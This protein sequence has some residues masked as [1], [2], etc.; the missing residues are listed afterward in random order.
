[1]P[2]VYEAQVSSPITF[3]F[4][5]IDGS[6]NLVSG[7]AA[8]VAVALRDEDGAAAETVTITEQGSSG[9]YE[10]TFT[11]TKGASTGASY[12]LQLTSPAGTDGAIIQYPI[13]VYSS[14][15]PVSPVSGSYLT[16]LAHL[17]QMLGIPDAT[18]TY[19]DLL[20]NVIAR[21]SRMIEGAL[22]VPIVEASYQEISDGKGS[23]VHVLRRKP[24]TDV[25]AVYMGSDDTWDS[26]TLVDPTNYSVDANLPRIVLRSGVFPWGMLN[27]RV[28]YTAGYSTIPLDVEGYCLKKCVELW[29]QRQQLGLTSIS[30]KDGS[31]SRVASAKTQFDDLMFEIGQYAHVW[32]T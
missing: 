18:T 7:E 26:T 32:V 20:T 14:I 25:T 29:N 31:I 21:M 27:V 19:D 9:Y 28:D 11:P 5:L 15:T 6:G 10:A 2:R 22:G 13:R 24:V 1:M 8:N 16:T 17:K 30:L 23:A 12:L 4:S 3:L